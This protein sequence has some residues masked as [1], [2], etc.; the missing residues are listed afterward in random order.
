MHDTFSFSA[1]L[2]HAAAIYQYYESRRR[3][4]RDEQDSRAASVACNQAA[5]KKYC[6]KQRVSAVQMANHEQCNLGNYVHNT[7]IQHL[8]SLQ[9]YDRRKRLCKYPSEH[10]AWDSITPH[11]MSLEESD[12]DS[13]IVHKPWWRST[14]KYM[15]LFTY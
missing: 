11:Y 12:N 7:V 8:L 15:G 2:T 9:L 14:S 1:I 6:R 3:K 4:H 5:T 13:F 10:N